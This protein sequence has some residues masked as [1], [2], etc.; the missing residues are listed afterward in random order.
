MPDAAITKMPSPSVSARA[1]KLGTLEAARGLAALLVALFHG[2]HAVELFRMGWSAPFGGFFEF[3]YAGVPFFFVLS[4]FI[5]FHVHHGDLN[6]PSR[7]AN[8]SWKRVTRIYPLFLVVMVP[9]TAKHL[10]AGSFEW[11]H[12]VKSLLLLPQAAPPMLIPSW[13]LV[14]EFMFYMLFGLAIWNL[15]LG[16]FVL[17][18]WLLLYCGIAGFD[19]DAGPGFA[20][21]LVRTLFSTHNLLFLLGVAVAWA[22]HRGRWPLRPGR[23]AVLGCL[24]F[25]GT[26]L[27]EISGRFP[28]LN[29]GMTSV[30]AYGLSSAFI[31]AGLVALESAGAIR[32]GRFAIFLGSLSYPLYLVHGMAISVFIAFMHEVRYD[33]PGWLLLVLAVAFACMAATLLNRCVEMPMA[34]YLKRVWSR[35][36]QLHA[37]S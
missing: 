24:G 6:R 14:H 8:F 35:R 11:G 1:E 7:L 15:R 10:A 32:A 37:Y 33:G 22:I 25:L 3:G 13:T 12:F 26:G 16:Q 29:Q 20:G 30:L 9:V 5:I 34:G 31:I 4:G 18:A 19:F 36:K 23:L 28:V 2:S 21:D 27:A 17:A